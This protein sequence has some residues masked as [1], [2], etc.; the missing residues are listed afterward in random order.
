MN[1]PTQLTLK[2]EGQD[3]APQNTHIIANCVTKG[4]GSGSN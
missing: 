2:V 4:T 1:T 3:M